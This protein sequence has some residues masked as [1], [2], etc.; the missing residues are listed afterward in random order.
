M[1]ESDAQHQDN[2]LKN[3][4]IGDIKHVKI[5]FQRV[6]YEA[7]KFVMPVTAEVVEKLI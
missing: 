7:H 5:Q 1:I 2:A 3:K 6:I 4:L